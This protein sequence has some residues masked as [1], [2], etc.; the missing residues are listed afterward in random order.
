M[1]A[2][3]KRNIIIEQLKAIKDLSSV[4]GPDRIPISAI[5]SITQVEDLLASEAG[6]MKVYRIETGGAIYHFAGRNMG[7]AL[8]VAWTGFADYDDRE[9]IENDGLAISPLKREEWPK[10]YYDLQSGKWLHF[11]DLVARIKEPS[12]LTCSEWP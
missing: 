2:V 12:V 4:L 7:E 1:M 9:S 11:A 10:N 5:N 6:P 8:E 3:T